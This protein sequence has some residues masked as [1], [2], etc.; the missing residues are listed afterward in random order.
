VRTILV[1]T[2]PIHTDIAIPVDARTLRRFGFLAEAGLPATH[3]QA[4]WMVFGWGSRAF[5]IETPTW[6]RLKPGPALA[7][8]TVDRSVI[9]VSIAGDL[10]PSHPSVTT[11]E[12]GEAKFGRL[13]DFI[14][15]G[16]Q[17]GP[18]G[19][20][21]IPGTAYGPDDGFFEANGWFTAL[22]GCNTWTARGLREA[23]LQTGWWNP[24]PATLAWSLE[25]HN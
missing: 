13:M 12:I 25:L 7:A 4:R 20:V 17:K 1:L 9:H 24:L 5:Y 3:P 10:D 16:F 23:G 11:Y 2:N 18:N 14:E 21:S 15:A 19:P 22:L 6:D 8:M